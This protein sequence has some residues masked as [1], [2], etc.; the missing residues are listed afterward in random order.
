MYQTAHARCCLQVLAAVV[1]SV[2]LFGDSPELAPLTEELTTLRNAA[3]VTAFTVEMV[4]H[5]ATIRDPVQLRRAMNAT[6]ARMA[7]HGLQEEAFH[8]LIYQRAL[9][10]R[11]ARRTG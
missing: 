2:T 4:T 3:R 9:E 7:G 6:F 11:R 1:D 8:D 5:L 10:V